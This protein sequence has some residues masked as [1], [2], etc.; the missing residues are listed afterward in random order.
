MRNKDNIDNS[1]KVGL[2]FGKLTIMDVFYKFT[3]GRNVLFT[4]C[5]CD[6]GTPKYIRYG[7]LKYNHTFSCGCYKKEIAGAQSLKSVY[8]KNFFKELTEESA[9]VL[10]LIASD[11]FMTRNRYE[12]GICLNK[13]DD[14]LLSTIGLLLRNDTRVSCKDKKCRLVLSNKEMYSDLLAWGI[15]PNK[16]LTLKIHN[17]LQNNRHFWRGMIDGDGCIGTFSKRKIFTL[18]LCGN[19]DVCK[20]FKDFCKLS[21]VKSKSKIYIRKDLEH[22]RFGKYALGIH[23]S[24]LICNLL[25]KDS[26]I[27]LERKYN[28]YLES[29]S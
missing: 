8:N 13:P 19:I 22:L 27:F 4:H 29:V 7:D 25:Y 10:G 15:H 1:S 14:E 21:G 16:S 6:C 18:Y 9:Y 20:S 23:D 17:Q 28:A 2:R 24:K 11:G 26:T 3:S 5:Q 12:F